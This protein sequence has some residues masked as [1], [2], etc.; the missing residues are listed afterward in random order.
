MQL[1]RTTATDPLLNSTIR[2]T[3]ITLHCGACGFLV[4]A[5][6][7]GVKTYLCRFRMDSEKFRLVAWWMLAVHM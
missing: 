7:L 4:T 5:R 1:Q 3:S 6:L 2:R